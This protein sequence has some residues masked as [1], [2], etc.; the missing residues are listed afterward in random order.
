M[1]DLARSGIGGTLHG[2]DRS[3]T[4]LG[5]ANRRADSLNVRAQW[6]C[7]DVL[8]HPLPFADASVD[9]VVCSLFLHHLTGPEVSRLLTEM[10]RVA[11]IGLIVSDL[12]R[13]TYGLTIAAIAARLATRSHI[14]HVDSVKSVR[15]A[16]TPEELAE[17]AQQAGLTGASIRRITPA[18]LL[19]TWMREPR[20]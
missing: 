10:A 9:L 4:A 18:R 17:L 3:T 15:A 16:W 8:Q 1:L 7:V 2:V 13:S 14:V 12:R 5:I 20:T 19:L 6:H 11:R